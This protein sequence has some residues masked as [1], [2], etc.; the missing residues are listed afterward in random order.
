VTGIDVEDERN[1]AVALSGGGHRATVFGLGALLAIAD[2]G[3]NRRVVSIS[4]VSGGSIANGIVMVGP[5]YGAATAAEIGQGV[6]SAIGA[7]SKRGVL[8]GGAPATR[9]YVR[10]LIAMAVV[11]GAALLAVFVTLIGHWWIPA[12]IAAIVLLVGGAITWWLV[13]QRSART[14]AAIDHELLGASSVTLNAV[15][16]RNLSTHHVICTTEMQSGTPFYFSNRMVYGYGFGGNTGPVALPLST[17]VQ[18]SACVP[19]AFAPRVIPLSDLGLTGAGRIVLTDGGTYDNMAD[20]WEYGYVNRRRLW[21]GLSIA[22]GRPAGLLVVV[23][24]SGGWNDTK[25][26]GSSGLQQELAGLLR[27]QGVQYDVSTAHRRRALNAMFREAEADGQGLDGLFAQITDS[28]YV[29]TRKFAARPGREPDEL[30]RRADEARRYLDGQDG[31]S[32]AVWEQWAKD[33][34][35]VSTTLAPLGPDVTAKLLEHGYVLTRVNMYVLDG[36]GSL[37]QPIDRTRL[38]ALCT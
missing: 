1:I 19:G 7:I 29:V 3:L 34:S 2:A 33:T 30:A 11:S 27:S 28:P 9:N 16:Q 18:A 14:E 36:L 12:I 6:S 35:G 22:Q 23:N 17:A 32:E 24:G 5:D 13:R 8:L 31:Y 26:I 4:S 20:E 15:R 37:E 38:R 21:D 25:P 10:L